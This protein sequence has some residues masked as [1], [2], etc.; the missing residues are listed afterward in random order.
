MGFEPISVL[1]AVQNRR[2]LPTWW[3][4]KRRQVHG[5]RDCEIYDF[6][7]QRQHHKSDEVSM[8]V[9]PFIRRYFSRETV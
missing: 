9:C 2:K 5:S 3:R 7:Y 1:S 6:H 8:T 4:Q